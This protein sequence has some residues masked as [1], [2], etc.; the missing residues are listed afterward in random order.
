M[1][2]LLAGS[3]A[4]GVAGFATAP[5]E[6]ARVRMQAAQ[7]AGAASGGLW[8]HLAPPPGV[9]PLQRVGFLWTG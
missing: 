6:L 8:Q 3:V 9:S 4:R 1:G 7:R 2:P 5:L